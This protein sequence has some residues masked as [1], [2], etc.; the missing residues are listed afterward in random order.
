MRIRKNAGFT[1]IE[2]LIV[3]A[4][5]GIIA[6]IAVPGLMRARMSGN[7]ASAIGSLRA[8][9]S[10][11]S[12]FASSCAA[13]NYAVTLAGLATPPTGSAVGA[14]GFI[15]ADLRLDPSVKSGYTITM[16]TNGGTAAKTT[17]CNGVTPESTYYVSA[18]PRDRGQHRPARFCHEPG[19]HDLAGY[20]G[21]GA[22]RAVRRRRHRQRDSVAIARAC[23]AMGDARTAFPFP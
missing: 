17:A 23:V 19:R 16:A 3:V 21:H 15:S 9:N 18:L 5:I 4:I 22:C 13:G 1:L 11:Q 2:L 20:D 8:I 7:E 14:D 6:A 12:T 10:S